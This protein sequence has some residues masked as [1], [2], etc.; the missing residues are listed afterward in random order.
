M[1]DGVNRPNELR[2]RTRR[3][4][5]RSSFSRG[6]LVLACA[7]ITT[8]LWGAVIYGGSMAIGVPI[9][10]GLL[11]AVLGPIFL[12]LLLSLSLFAKPAIRDS[13]TRVTQ[14]Q[15][16]GGFIPAASAGRRKSFAA[17]ADPE[18]ARR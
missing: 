16:L 3:L 6:S 5:G 4:I 1:S 18:P 11:A 8:A 14:H 12:F 15:A 13:G 9:D 7:F 10:P 17:R 2:G